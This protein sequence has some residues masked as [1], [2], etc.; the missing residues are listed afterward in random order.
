MPACT[1]QHTHTRA[2]AR[3]QLV[4]YTHAHA[5]V[6]RTQLVAYT[7]AHA[8]VARTK[9]AAYTHAHARGTHS[10]AHPRARVYRAQCP[11]AVELACSTILHV[12]TFSLS[13][14]Y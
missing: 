13:H 6:A 7:H 10:H 2:P 4:A 9:L 11:S 3:T 5:R 12:Q 8:R 1:L 14:L